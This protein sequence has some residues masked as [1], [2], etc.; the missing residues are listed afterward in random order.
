MLVPCGTACTLPPVAGLLRSVLVPSGTA[1]TPTL[2]V[3]V[4][5]GTAPPSYARCWFLAEPHPL[6]SI[7]PPSYVPSGTAPPTPTLPR[8]CFRAEPAPLLRPSQ[9]PKQRHWMGYCSLPL[10]L[11]FCLPNTIR[12]LNWTTKALLW[13]PEDM[14]WYP[15]QMA[16]WKELPTS[17]DTGLEIFSKGKVDFFQRT[18]VGSWHS[19][20][21]IHLGAEWILSLKP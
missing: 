3:L 20:S 12:H 8:C 1:P 7:P 18:V 21:S 5:S 6:P 17:G 2:S 10:F 13:C 15:L 14:V 19:N 9:S 11:S 16:W 4:P